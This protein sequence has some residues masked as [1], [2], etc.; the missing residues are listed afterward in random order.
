MIWDFDEELVIPQ[1]KHGQR[2]RHDDRCSESERRTEV[3]FRITEDA[4]IR[5]TFH[6]SC[7]DFSSRELL[8]W[9]WLLVRLSSREIIMCP[10]MRDLVSRLRDYD[11]SL[12]AALPA[13][14]SNPG[15][16]VE[17]DSF[18]GCLLVFLVLLKLRCRRVKVLQ[19]VL[20]TRWESSSLFCSLSLSLNSNVVSPHTRESPSS[21]GVQVSQSLFLQSSFQVTYG[22][23][24]TCCSNLASAATTFFSWEQEEVSCCLFSSHSPLVAILCLCLRFSSNVNSIYDILFDSVV[25]VVHMHWRP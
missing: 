25:S 15:E 3:I 2:K 20:K 13:Q 6:D 11:L 21:V 8:C 14:V 10:A 18:A 4:W 22:K 7:W 24:Y 17:Q 16:E 9:T 1:V 23:Q 12:G 19:E 5:G